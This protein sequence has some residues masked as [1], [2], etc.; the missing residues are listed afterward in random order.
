MELSDP[1]KALYVIKLRNV[2]KLCTLPHSICV[3]SHNEIQLLIYN[4]INRLAFILD[5]DYI[6]VYVI[7]MDLML[8][9]FKVISSD[10]AYLLTNN[11][12]WDV[13]PCSLVERYQ[14]CAATSQK[15]V[16]VMR[17]SSV[18]QWCCWKIEVS[19]DMTLCCWVPISRRFE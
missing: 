12:N 18:G 2:K 11:I 16:A 10:I 1:F 4:I 9:K 5:T 15:T 14:T 8:E 19:W 13:A 3:N 7:Q 17:N 6:S